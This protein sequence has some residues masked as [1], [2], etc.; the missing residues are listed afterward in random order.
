MSGEWSR[1]QRPLVLGSPSQAP[2]A[3]LEVDSL[4]ASP[5]LVPVTTTGV[6]TSPEIQRL[7]RVFLFGRLSAGIGRVYGTDF[8]GT[9]R[10]SHEV[11]VNW[12]R[13]LGRL[14]NLAIREAW[15]LQPGETGAIVLR[16]VRG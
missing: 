13:P 8:R 6:G 1:G 5:S 16:L 2:G 3:G 9:L 4:R 14:R 10:V 11:W 7:H 12:E 15:M